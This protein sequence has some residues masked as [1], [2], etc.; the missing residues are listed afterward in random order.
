MAYG[1]RVR[2]EEGS[3]RIFSS[4]R[5][6]V[7]PDMLDIDEANFIGDFVFIALNGL[8]M[9][10]GS[11]ICA[12]AKLVGMGR[13][14][15]GR[16][17]VVGYDAH[18]ITGTDTPEGT[19]MNDAQPE[20]LRSVVRGSI[21]IGDRCFTGSHVVICVSKENPD[22]DIGNDVVIMAHSY[23]DRSIPSNTIYGKWG[24]EEISKPR[25]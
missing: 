1:G 11:Q 24:S 8:L 15:I 16:D 13:V 6:V 10:R 20:S 22:I 9:G 21:T 19:Y 23:V 14:S 25:F 7:S 3:M 2:F 5:I 18:L 17:S 4:A 12:G